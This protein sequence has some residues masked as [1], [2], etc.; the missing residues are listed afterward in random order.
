MAF[1]LNS[2]LNRYLGFSNVE[3]IN[4]SDQ[5]EVSVWLKTRL[6]RCFWFGKSYDSIFRCDP[7]EFVSQSSQT[8]VVLVKL[9][10]ESLKYCTWFLDKQFACYCCCRLK[11][12]FKR[13][14]VGL[15]NLS[16]SLS[17]GRR[18]DN[19]MLIGCLHNFTHSP[20]FRIITTFCRNSRI[21]NRQFNQSC[22]RGWKKLMIK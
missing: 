6:R 7:V 2:Y 17:I 18:S 16:L 4:S 15:W 12:S 9:Q 3:P 14:I 1:P 20:L 8:I 22:N 21:S 13:K 19:S 10:R 5:S 11:L